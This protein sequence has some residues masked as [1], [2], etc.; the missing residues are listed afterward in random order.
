MYNS[1]YMYV[2]PPAHCRV[3]VSRARW[4]IVVMHVVVCPYWKLL[5]QSIIHLFARPD[6]IIISYVLIEVG[7]CGW[8]CNFLLMET[9]NYFIFAL[10]SG[11]LNVLSSCSCV[12]YFS[13]IFSEMS[14]NWNRWRIWRLGCHSFMLLDYVCDFVSLFSKNI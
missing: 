5:K 13:C 14:L 12:S 4:I 11:L 1:L 6:I 10:F 2:Y 7:M 3:C 8:R 9:C